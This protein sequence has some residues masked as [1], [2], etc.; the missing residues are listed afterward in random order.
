MLIFIQCIIT[1][2]NFVLY[3]MRD[4]LDKATAPAVKNKQCVAYTGVQICV[5]Q[6]TGGYS[7]FEFYTGADYAVRNPTT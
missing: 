5:A 4:E 7:W 6:I 2:L 3:S 1:L